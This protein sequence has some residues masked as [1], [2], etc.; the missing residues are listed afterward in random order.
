MPDINLTVKHGRTWAEARS[1]LQRVVNEV[2]T[3][4][5]ALVQRVEWSA[6][7][8]SVQ[9]FGT[10]FEIEMRVDAHQVYVTGN[11]P[12]LGKLLGGPLVSGLKQLVEQTFQKRLT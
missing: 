4:F 8:N 10:G 6:D 3:K 12:F 2:Q 5:G 7:Q 1:H 11:V 9:L